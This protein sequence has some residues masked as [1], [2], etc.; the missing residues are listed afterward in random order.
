MKPTLMLI[1]LGHLGGA[2]L[3]LLAGDK[4]VGRIV[5]CSRNRPRGAARCNVARLGALAQGRTP[6]I[7]FLS[8][9][10]NDSHAIV[11]TIQRVAPDIILNTA[12]LQTWWLLDLLPAEPATALRKAGFGVWLPVHL[13]LTL[14][15]MQAVRKSGYDGV[16]L[17]ASYPDV[18]NCILGR[19]G[20]APTCGVGNLD[21]IV[22]KLR[23]LAAERLEVSAAEV[24]VLMVAH[25]ALERVVFRGSEAPAGEIPPYFLRL[26]LKGEDVTEE[27]AAEGLLLTPYP[28]PSGPGWSH[29][30]ACSAVRLVRALLADRPS[31]LH[32][33]G[34][35]GL[36]GGYPVL[37]AGGEV[38]PAPLEG[39]SLGAAIDINERSHIFDGIERIAEDGTAVFA[40][41]SAAIM[42]SE[43]GYDCDRLMPEEAEER[44]TELIS[45]FEDYAGRQGVDLRKF[46]AGYAGEE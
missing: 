8:L 10:L 37:V 3:D 13:T 11:E 19:I 43:L 35:G 27:I 41:A 36:P 7:D 15:L 6:R 9:D 31:L 5:G 38:R 12:S 23:L 16:T 34:P 1:G 21:E 4:T 44:G 2:V 33:P 18:I 29:L 32:A 20:L 28:L 14:K 30:T 24:A 17:T 42:R 40:P 25:H 45:R 46:A 39:L 26:L 22:P